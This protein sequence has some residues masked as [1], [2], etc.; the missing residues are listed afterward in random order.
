MGMYSLKIECGSKY[1]EECPVV[2]FYTRINM[3][4]VHN[5]TG[6][7]DK[8]MVS[9]L[10]KWQRNYT[11]KTMLQT[12]THDDPQRKYE[13]ATTTRRN[14]LLIILK[15]RLAFFPFYIQF[16][17]IFRFPF[18]KFFVS[19]TT[20][21]PRGSVENSKINKS[22]EVRLFCWFSKN[23]NLSPTSRSFSLGLFR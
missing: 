15:N 21:N 12:A 7:V 18:L 23:D 2:R 19:L 16:V 11:I 8:R 17:L 14:Y 3:N 22:N 20:G 5:T 13:T 4:G 9:T 1:P 6:M 10:I